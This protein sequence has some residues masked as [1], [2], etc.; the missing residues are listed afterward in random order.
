MSKD[1]KYLSPE[2]LNSISNSCN[3]Y[4]KNIFSD[5]LYKTSKEFNSDIAGIGKHLAS[6]FLTIQDWE[7]YNWLE[8]YKNTFFSVDVNTNIKSS[9]L[10]SE[11]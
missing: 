11:T 2:V 9:H 5:Y 4:L 1:S 7:N 8:N 3:S 6:Q 10:L